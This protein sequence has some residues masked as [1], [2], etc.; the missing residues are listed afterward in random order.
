MKTIKEVA[1]KNIYDPHI[2]ILTVLDINEDGLP[3]HV[4]VQRLDE[5]AEY[6]GEYTKKVYQV[7]TL[8]IGVTKAGMTMGDEKESDWLIGFGIE[9]EWLLAIAWYCFV[10]AI[11]G[12]L[13]RKRKQS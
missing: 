2:K 11:C 1:I 5:G 4:L 9:R 10:E 13:H 7:S 6:K 3:N 12:W 8:A